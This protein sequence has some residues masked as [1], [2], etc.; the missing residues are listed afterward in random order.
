MEAAESDVGRT[1]LTRGVVGT[2]L[3]M[4][5]E[6][7]RG[8]A[9]GVYTD[10]YALGCMLV[11]MLTGQQAVAGHSIR[12]LQRAHC[13]GELRPV[14][15]ELPEGARPEHRR[16]V[17]TC[18]ARCVAREPEARYATWEALA[19]ALAEAYSGL[20][21]QAV[22]A[23]L[24]AAALSRAERVAHGW[25]YNAM[26]EAYLD[27]GKAAVAVDYF[28]RAST[29]GAEAS[30]PALRGAALGNLGLAYARLGE[31]RRA[32]GYY[33]EQ[34]VI[35]REIG[36]RHGEGNALGNLGSA[37]Y[38][39]GEVRRAIGYY[40]QALLI[41]QEIGDIAG[42]ATD[43]FNM[44]LLYQQQGDPAR[45]LP[46]AQEA[47]RIFARI[48]RPNAQVAQQLVAQ[49][50]A[51]IEAVVAAAGG[52][53]QARAAVEG[54]FAQFE[55]GGWRIVEPIQRIWAGER[56]EESLTAG[57][58]ANSALIVREILKRL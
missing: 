55:Q 34:L 6:Q 58:D 20:S 7:W 46:L 47:A 33:E 19:D 30:E 27:L 57:I 18:V 35:T 11:E 43:S 39:L 45:A 28:E 29:V 38:C 36:D 12:A 17:R 21:G 53:A 25:S 48:G 9:V 1:R 16:R 52:H 13:A 22:P 5:P 40:E 54:L 24:P 56:D 37:Y 10:V 3:Y 26:G 14:P 32:I 44:A 8:E 42:V 23:A 49:F 50:S 31:V 15:Q 41:R 4:A 51:V 2:P